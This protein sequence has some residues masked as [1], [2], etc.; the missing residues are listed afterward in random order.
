MWRSNAPPVSWCLLELSSSQPASHSHRINYALST[1]ICIG[2]RE[3]KKK[4][5]VTK[6]TINYTIYERWKNRWKPLTSCFM[7]AC[8][9]K[10][11]C[12]N[13][14]NSVKLVKT[15][16]FNSLSIVHNVNHAQEKGSEDEWEKKNCRMAKT[17]QCP[18]LQVR[19]YEKSQKIQQATLT[20]FLL[21]CRHVYAYDS[22]EMEIWR[23]LSVLQLFSQW[24]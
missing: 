19:S 18:H 5:T 23:Y 2:T 13:K 14:N 7:Q 3:R 20:S 11:H 6:H 17:A 1:Y 24:I 10:A 4:K 22:A 9:G 8:L 12:Y 21:N 16:F 15:V